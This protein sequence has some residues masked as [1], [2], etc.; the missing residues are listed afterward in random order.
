[1]TYT[2][3]DIYSYTVNVK[4]YFLCIVVTSFPVPEVDCTYSYG[5]TNYLRI[6]Y[7][8][9]HA[10]VDIQDNTNSECIGYRAYMYT[11]L[12]FLYTFRYIADLIAIMYVYYSH[13]IIISNICSSTYL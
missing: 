12:V 10:L 3:E 13:I 1:M 8:F 9:G 7:G 11:L 6:T 5:P 2:A 4:V